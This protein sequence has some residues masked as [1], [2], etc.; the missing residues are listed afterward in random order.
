MGVALIIDKRNDYE[1]EILTLKGNLYQ[2]AIQN[3]NLEYQFN[4]CKLLYKGM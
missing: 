3:Q 4:M 2:A 1:K